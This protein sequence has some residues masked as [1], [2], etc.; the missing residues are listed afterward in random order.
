MV[1]DSPDTSAGGSAAQLPPTPRPTPETPA[2]PAL[3]IGDA[4]RH[5][6]IGE[7]RTQVGDGRL[8]LD[9]FAERADQVWRATTALEL[10]PVLADLP[11][12]PTTVSPP[13]GP[14]RP[15]SALG[16]EA[17]TMPTR[18]RRSIVAVMSGTRVR[19]RWHV[20]PQITVTAF[21]GSAHV[22]LRDAIF[23]SPVVDINAVAIM[24]SITV[25]VPEG[26]PVELDGT[27][28]MGGCHNRTPADLVLPGAPVVR[29]HA[30]GMWADIDVRSRPSG[31]T[32]VPSELA[33]PP[34]TPE[35]PDATRPAPGPAAV[36]DRTRP[37]P[38]AAPRALPT[39]TLTMLFTDIVGSTPLVEELG[40]Q[41]WSQVMRDHDTAVRAVVASHAGT[42]VK[43]EGDGYLIVFV[44]ARQAVLAALGLQRAV[45][46]LDHDL[47]GRRLAIRTGLHTGEV[48]AQEGDVFGRNVIA[49]ARIAAEAAPGQVLVSSLTK[50]L[51]DSSGD[52]S[53]DEGREIELRGLAR[54]WRIHTVR[55]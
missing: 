6:V 28:L 29:V 50:E 15:A 39:G 10:A 11:A 45:Q 9:E 53:F 41:R 14:V 51:V 8:T 13:A 24:G 19:G 31:V 54:P 30:M 52:L 34:T 48:V 17:A 36:A 33:P 27:V 16:P 3:R 47:P 46:D 4:E 7:L 49:A 22:D 25:T 21:W 55:S 5:R 43:V 26:I 20:A 35:P 23:M 44:S 18:G 32:E 40:D 1:G 12:V 37:D 38:A 2:A 42:V